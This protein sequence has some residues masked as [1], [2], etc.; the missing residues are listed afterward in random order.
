MDRLAPHAQL[1]D[2]R[3]HLWDAAHL[4]D[5]LDAEPFKLHEHP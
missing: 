3:L 5:A 1:M 2:V 4:D